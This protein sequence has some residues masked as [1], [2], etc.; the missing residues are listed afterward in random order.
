MVVGRGEFGPVR[1]AWTDAAA[2]ALSSLRMPEILGEQQVRRYASLRG[3][4]AQR[5]LAGRRLLA[6]LI[7]ELTDEADLGFTT[8][9]ERCGADHGRPRMER[10]PVAVSVSYA[11]SMVAV[12]A[13]ALTDA[14]GVGVDIEREPR[15]G[16]HGRLD[17]L[18][19]L[20]A[21]AAAPDTEGWT[22]VEAA[23]KADG[24]GVTV[25]LAEIQVCEVGTGRLTGSRAVRIPGRGSVDAAVIVG[26]PGFVLSAAMVPEAGERHPE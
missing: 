15:G 23:L 26:P 12:A 20:F 6:E 16:A 18:A 3:I 13:A 9:C 21:P 24:R 25:D 19:P 4:P 5:F 22:L 8:T 17:D 10:A 2:S 11:G 14:A 1:V 7:A